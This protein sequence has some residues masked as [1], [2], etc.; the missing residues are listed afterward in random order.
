MR[1]KNK[2][3]FGVGINDASYE[4][5]SF[6]RRNGKYAVAWRCPLYSA[7]CGMLGRCYNERELRRAPTY[8][9]CT[10][11]PEWLKFSS[12]SS[13]M[14]TQG[15]SG[16]QLDKDILCPGNK[17]YAADRCVFVT[18]DLNKFLTDAGAAR[19]EWPIGVSWNRR[20][21]RFQ[22]ACGNP[23]TG[24]RDRLGYF[25]SPEAA[26]EAWRERKHKYAC[27]YADIQDDLRIS[28]ALRIRYLKPREA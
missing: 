21:K 11:C 26:H 8:R 9:G 27:A 23:F 3:L 22:A 28:A 19:G 16:K 20:D 4:V 6:E 1:A 14:A 13:W 15:Y 25:L 2:L 17:L 24:T 18:Q 7:W 12:F 5:Y 10:V